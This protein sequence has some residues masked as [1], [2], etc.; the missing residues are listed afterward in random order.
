MRLTKSCPVNLHNSPTQ[1]HPARHNLHNIYIFFCWDKTLLQNL[2]LTG[3]RLCQRVN[4]ATGWGGGKKT[5]LSL[6]DKWHKMAALPCLKSVHRST[7]PPHMGPVFCLLAACYCYNT[8]KCYNFWS[9]LFLYCTGEISDP[10][11]M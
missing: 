5:Q 8:K 3:E 2:F 10:S 6:N 1:T 4:R 7:P 11:K 9:P